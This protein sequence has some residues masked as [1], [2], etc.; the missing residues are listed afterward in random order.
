MSPCLPRHLQT[1]T[2][3]DGA[4][5]EPLSASAVVAAAVAAAIDATHSPDAH[6]VG[7]SA[8]VLL[9]LLLPVV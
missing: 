4:D 9:I 5:A 3:A 1:N 8:A 6:D 7:A 2:A